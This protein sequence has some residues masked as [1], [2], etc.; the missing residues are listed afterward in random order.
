MGRPIRST[1]ILGVIFLVTGTGAVDVPSPFPGLMVL[2]GLGMLIVAS[3]MALNR[4]RRK[5]LDSGPPQWPSYVSAFR[6]TKRIT[7][8]PRTTSWPR[9]R[10][11]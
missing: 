9:C 8:L 11:R 2:I 5:Y 3:G 6:D 10:D 7:V 4:R 1:V